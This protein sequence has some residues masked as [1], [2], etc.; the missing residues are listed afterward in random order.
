MYVLNM[1]DE[2]KIISTISKSLKTKVDI[3]SNDKNTSNWDSLGHLEIL[4]SLD[5]LS[6]G[7]IANIKKISVTT[8]VKGILKILKKNKLL[9]KSKW[10]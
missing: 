1:L 2:N 6:K 7:K 10:V 4:A 5:K 3:N 8:N 9:Y